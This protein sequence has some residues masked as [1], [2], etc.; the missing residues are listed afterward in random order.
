MITYRVY[1]RRP[2]KRDARY[3]GGWS[4]NGGARKTTVRR[5]VELAEARRICA[6]GNAHVVRGKPGQLYYEFESE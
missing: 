2:W 5:G 1:K 6:E 4:P 3:P